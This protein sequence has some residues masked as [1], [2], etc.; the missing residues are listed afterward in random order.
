MVCVFITAIYDHYLHVGNLTWSLY[1]RWGVEMDRGISCVVG[2]YKALQEDL[3]AAIEAMI[4][5]QLQ[6]DP[7]ASSTRYT[8]VFPLSPLSHSMP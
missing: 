2:E 1:N 4:G 5:V 8:L 3:S 7:D 6:Q